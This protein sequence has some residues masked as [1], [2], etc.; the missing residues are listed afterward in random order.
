MAGARALL[1]S[2]AIGCAAFSLCCGGGDE[3][4][5]NQC[6]TLPATC[7]LG[8]TPSYAEIYTTILSKS[9]GA[10][11]G[12][13]CHGPDGRQGGLGLYDADMAY[14]DLLGVT[15]HARVIPENPE[16]SSLVERL[17]SDDPSYRM[18]Y[19]GA[20]L[21]PDLLCAVQTWIRD[22]ATKN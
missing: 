3:P 4:A 2:V 7:T 20:K 21:A 10:G 15:G 22:G 18:P 17:N 8:I 6:V 5:G 19:M 9:C 12:A 13:N 11:M 1:A 14:N 16:C